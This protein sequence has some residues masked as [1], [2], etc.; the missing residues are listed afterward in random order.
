MIIDCSYK[1]RNWEGFFDVCSLGH[2]RTQTR[3]SGTFWNTTARKLWRIGRSW[4]TDFITC[5]K[6]Y[7]KPKSSGTRWF[8]LLLL[9]GFSSLPL[10]SLGQVNV[11][12]VLV[13]IVPCRTL[14]SDWSEGC[15][16][17]Y[18]IYNGQVLLR[19]KS[20]AIYKLYLYSIITIHATVQW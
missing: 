8:H 9:P 15:D 5:T 11:N 19:S 13:V 7:G 16:S 1:S 17:F 18:L 6:N 14:N 3:P 20:Q 12:T 2:W 4:W 10:S